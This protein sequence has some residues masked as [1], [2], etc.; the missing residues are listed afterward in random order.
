MRSLASLF[1]SGKD[2][3]RGDLVSGVHK[4][5]CSCG[6]FYIGRTHQKFIEHR[7]SIKKPTIKRAS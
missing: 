1:N 3:A 6:K 4:I 7:D 5:P 2:L